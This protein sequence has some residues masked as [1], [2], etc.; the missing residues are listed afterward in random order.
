MRDK[1]KYVQIGESM[2]TFYFNGFSHFMKLYVLI[3]IKSFFQKMKTVSNHTSRV[4]KCNHPQL[5]VLFIIVF[6]TQYGHGQP[7]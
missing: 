1:L 2:Y 7:K 5:P 4:F 3:L 6:P